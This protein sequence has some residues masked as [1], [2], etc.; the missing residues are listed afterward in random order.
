MF[1]IRNI[2]KGNE[3]ITSLNNAFL[4]PD[5]VEH[6]FANKI[7]LWLFGFFVLIIPIFATM[8]IKKYGKVKIF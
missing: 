8:K 2:F 5:N 1:F 3:Q 7:P 6:G 4:A